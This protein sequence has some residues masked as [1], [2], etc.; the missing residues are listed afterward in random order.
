MWGRVGKLIPVRSTARKIVS[1]F[2]DGRHE[3]S[4]LCPGACGARPRLVGD[5]IRLRRGHLRGHRQ[6]ARPARA[7]RFRDGPARDPGKSPRAGCLG[8]HHQSFKFGHDVRRASRT[9][10]ISPGR[11]PVE[12]FVLFPPHFMGRWIAARRRDGG[13]PRQ[14]RC[15]SDTLHCLPALTRRPLRPAADAAAHFPTMWGRKRALMLSPDLFRGLAAF[16]MQVQP[17]PC[18]F[19]VL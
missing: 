10:L 7:C 9:P 14:R 18:V 11:K 4:P 2:R 19:D 5:S 6:K 17:G 15:V 16:R 12:G 3:L 1:G 13:A 8:H